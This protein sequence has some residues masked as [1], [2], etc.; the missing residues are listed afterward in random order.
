MNLTPAEL[1][2]LPRRSKR[3]EANASIGT[4]KPEKRTSG[5]AVDRPL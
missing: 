2:L 4:R 5:R 1:I 3:A